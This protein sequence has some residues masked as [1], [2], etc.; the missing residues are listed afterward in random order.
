MNKFT[1]L[2]VLNAIHYQVT[3]ADCLVDALKKRNVKPK[4]SKEDKILSAGIILMSL[5]I[6]YQVFELCKKVLKTSKTES[7]TS[8]E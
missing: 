8:A 1:A 3:V 2:C 7:I 5:F 4:G 6:I